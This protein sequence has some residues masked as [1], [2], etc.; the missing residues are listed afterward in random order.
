MLTYKYNVG[1]SYGFVG[2][3]GFS[4]GTGPILLGYL[5][6]SGTEA[7]LV[8]CSQNY[9]ST[10]VYSECQSHYYDAAVLCECKL[11][12]HLACGQCSGSHA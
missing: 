12:N 4:Q 7:N 2:N 11:T 8:K 6:C 1:F 5:Y 10:H 9:Y 3:L